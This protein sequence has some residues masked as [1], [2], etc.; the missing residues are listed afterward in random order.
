MTIFN[1]SGI[2]HENA[3]FHEIHS[4]SRISSRALIFKCYHAFQCFVIRVQCQGC[5]NASKKLFLS[6]TGC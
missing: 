4:F 2:I 1:K 3:P 5:V 6:G